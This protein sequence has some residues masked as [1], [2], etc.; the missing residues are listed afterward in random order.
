MRFLVMFNI[1]HEEPRYAYYKLK[2][3]VL[4]GK[5]HTNY[6]FCAF[7]LASKESSNQTLN[8][9]HLR[10]CTIGFSGSELIPFPNYTVALQLH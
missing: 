7:N 4:K 8:L 3:R 10:V 6:S 5:C 1:P 9:N 2:A